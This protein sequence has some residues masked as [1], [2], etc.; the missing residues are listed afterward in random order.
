MCYGLFVS[1]CGC[2]WCVMVSLLVVVVVFGLL[3]SVCE[4]LWLPLVCY[5][6]FVSRCGCLWFVMVCL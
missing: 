5:G 2:L 3:W 4:W 1:G 6:L